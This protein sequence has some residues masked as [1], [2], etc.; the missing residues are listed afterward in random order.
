[1]KPS[2][3]CEQIQNLKHEIELKDS[4]IDTL[5]D[6]LGAS[7]GE[8]KLLEAKNRE[9]RFMVGTWTGEAYK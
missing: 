5:Y 9:L 7:E 3:L 2:L 4:V 8:R 1:M 6:M